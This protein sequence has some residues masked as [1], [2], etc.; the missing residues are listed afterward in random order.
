M[1]YFCLPVR[2]CFFLLCQGHDDKL[3][4]N[5]QAAWKEQENTSIRTSTL[6]KTNNFVLNKY[7]LTD[8]VYTIQ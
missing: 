8:W 1:D 5:N 3:L 6:N 4:N 2:A 7:I